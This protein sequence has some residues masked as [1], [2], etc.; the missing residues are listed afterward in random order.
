MVRAEVWTPAVAHW[1]GLH[2]HFDKHVPPAPVSETRRHTMG[3]MTTGSQSTTLVFTDV[4]ASTDL[5][6]RDREAM[7]QAL[8]LHDATVRR[9]LDEFGGRELHGVGD[10]FLSAWDD[11]IAAVRWGAR[12]QEALLEVEWPA[13]LLVLPG[14]GEVVSSRGERLFRG[15][16]VRMGA[17]VDAHAGDQPSQEAVRRAAR[18]AGAARGG[19]ILLSG[20]L[21]EV[22]GDEVS[23]DMV[24]TD[25]GYRRL[26]GIAGDERLI[27]VLPASVAARRF[28]AL[29][30]VDQRRS[31]LPPEITLFVGREDDLSALTE[32]FGFGARLVSVLGPSGI[33]KTR[34]AMR[35]ASRWVADYAHDGGVWQ[36]QLAEIRTPEGL[37]RA[38]A[39]ALDVPLTMGRTAADAV[40]QLGYALA[41]RGPTLLLL[42]GLDHPPAGVMLPK[43]LQAAPQL[44]I[45]VTA[46]GRLGLPGEIAYELGGLETEEEGSRSA[47]DL[48]VARAPRERPDLRTTGSDSAAAASTAHLV[49]GVPLALELVG[50]QPAAQTWA[51]L[52]RGLERWFQAVGAPPGPEQ[53]L[54]G[55]L[56]WIWEHLALWERELM[57]QMAVCRGG[58]DVTA[59]ERI[60]DL[61]AFPAAPWVPDVLAALCQ[62]CLLED[63]TL[64]DAPGTPRYRMHRAVREHVKLRLPRG[65]RSAAED[66]HAATYL[67]R[68]ER[69]AAEACGPNAL[70]ALA[71]LERERANLMAVHRRGLLRGGPRGIAWALRAVLA[72]DPLLRWR[73]PPEG[74]ILLLDQALA[75][76]DSSS[77]PLP[78]E[79]VTRAL[80]ARAAVRARLGRHHE[81]TADLERARDLA[82]AGK[83][84]TAEAWT[85]ADL[86]DHLR[87]T[88][89]LEDGRRATGR[90][91]AMAVE[92]GDVSLQATT[93]GLLGAISLAQRDL[94]RARDLLEDAAD[95]AVAVGDRLVE[96][97]AVGN[98]GLVA[99]F[100]GDWEQTEVLYRRAIDIH[101]Q[102]GDRATE[103]VWLGN[104][105]VLLLHRGELDEAE[106]TFH[107]SLALARAVGYRRA[108]A[109]A[110]TNLAL[111]HMLRGQIEP[112]REGFAAALVKHEA[113]DTTSG[114]ALCE[115]MIGVIAHQE[116]SV[117]EAADRYQR[118]CKLADKAGDPRWRTLARMWWSV[119]SEENGD[120]EVGA[121]LWSDAMEALEASQDAMLVAASEVLSLA[122]RVA[123]GEPVEVIV[124]EAERIAIDGLD[125]RVAS[126]W[127]RIRLSSAA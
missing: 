114:Q 5:W 54:D 34:L 4:E 38:V 56:G 124:E 116:G 19:Q 63:V 86:G 41:A 59:A 85:V 104:L 81:V 35:L 109:V 16:R 120:P 76:S 42:D 37:A 98:L 117:S 52:S 123:R 77:Q 57:A 51:D 64:A 50:A 88:G 23:R 82:V 96:G 113:T 20:A 108:A 115:V 43:W 13:G 89:R 58:F 62:R 69:W 8:R 65:R 14:A 30:T 103:G 80:R 95:R 32:L 99:R 26:R 27:Q 122:R 46:T 73:G 40:S 121:A 70:E 9:L 66:R 127:L 90:A 55:V 71:A 18:I 125:A 15:L 6:S 3:G 24:A 12:V 102:T 78:T 22:V 1:T 126:K 107:K 119:L 72:L 79:L 11:P 28:P 39:T 31:N 84:P 112:A 87:L 2:S 49:R 83:D 48:L 17:H 106:E 53:A 47:V 21:W 7:E 25:L 100:D 111:T 97:R 101:R 118:A 75:A 91:H 60:V 68:A 105:G 93:L 94:A 67:T 33:G 74:Q 110:H 10:A 45:L 29:D 36:A 61:T 44:R 92:L